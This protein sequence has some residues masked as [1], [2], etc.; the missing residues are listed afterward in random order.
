MSDF[1]VS[2]AWQVLRDYRERGEMI[3]AFTMERQRLNSDQRVVEDRL[4]GVE[5]ARGNLSTSL[6][7][8]ESRVKVSRGWRSTLCHD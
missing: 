2:S 8:T 6:H 7:T 5:R 1:C 4:S 3:K